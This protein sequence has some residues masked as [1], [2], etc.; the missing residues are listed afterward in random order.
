MD[1]FAG[2][3]LVTVLET[4][5]VPLSA[6]KGS[7]LT[8]ELDG[9][10]LQL[11]D[12]IG[13]MRMQAAHALCAADLEQAAAGTAL[14]SSQTPKRH[15]SGVAD[16]VLRAKIDLLEGSATGLHWQSRLSSGP[17]DRS[18]GTGARNLESLLPSV[19]TALH[20]GFRHFSNGAIAKATAQKVQLAPP[21]R[22]HLCLQ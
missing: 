1:V 13:Y 2:A 9:T 10:S 17:T 19:V 15:C 14:K 11:R 7:A 20:A 18:I 21:L 3:A 6:I 4:G 16:D 5:A 22:L 12:K 8:I